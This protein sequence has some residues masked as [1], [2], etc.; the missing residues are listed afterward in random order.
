MLISFPLRSVAPGQR[1]ATIYGEGTVVAF[2]KT[3]EDAFPKYRVKLPYGHGFLSPAAIL[4]AIPSQE[5]PFLR[6]DGAMVRDEDVVT[7]L[8]SEGQLCDRYNIVFGTE[9]VY[10]FLQQFSLLCSLLRDTRERCE[11]SH[12]PVDPATTYHDPFKRDEDIGAPPSKIFFP[13]IIDGLKKV[14]KGKMNTNELEAMARK[15]SRE[16]VHQV[17]AM[18]KFIER[19]ATALIETA[20]EDAILHLYDYCHRPKVDITSI[21]TH[22]FAIAPNA[23]YRIQYSKCSGE[24]CFSFVPKGKTLLVSP[25]DGMKSLSEDEHMSDVENGVSPLDDDEDDDV[26]EEYE[27]DQPAWKKIKV[28]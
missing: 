17:A 5:T 13:N 21:R 24:M 9:N 27:D 6:R 2:V 3:N 20:K 23:S 10:M 25:P 7:E 8:T 1:V 19:C 16:T 18:P 4:F 14:V 15:A 22:C 28:R 26:I 11:N 12:P